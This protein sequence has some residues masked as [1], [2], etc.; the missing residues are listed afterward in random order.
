MSNLAAIYT[1]I[2][3][4]AEG[5][6]VGVANQEAA[7][8]ALAERHGL[9][10][11]E[12]YSDND[13]GASIHSRKPRI[14]FE[15]MMRDAKA[16]RFGTVIAYSMSRVSRRPAE[17]EVLIQMGAAGL[18][19]V[20]QVSP[21]YDLNTADG[22][23]TARTVSAWDAA[24]AERTSERRR[25]RNDGNTAKGRPA[26]RPRVFGYEVDG[27]TPR[28]DEAELLRAG[29]QHVLD[30]GTVRSLAARWNEEG[31]RS[32]RGN[33]W[34]TTVVRNTLLRER[35][36]GI[37]IARGERVEGSQIIPIVD[38]EV[39]QAVRAILTDAT[40]TTKG[41]PTGERW[42]S[43]AMQCQCG[44]PMLVGSSWSN[45][46][47]SP[48]YRCESISIAERSGVPRERGHSS[49][50]ASTV[51]EGVVRELIAT[52]VVEALTGADEALPEAADVV[53]LRARQSALEE[54]RR[55]AQDMYMLPGVDRAHLASRIARI[56]AEHDAVAADLDAAL[57]A[58]SSADVVKALRAAVRDILSDV[59]ADDEARGAAIREH[60]D[61]LSVEVRRDVVKAKLSITVAPGGSGAV[62]MKRVSIHPV[63][64][65]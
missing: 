3:R 48:A 52:L 40:R 54:E 13:R 1:R 30:G 55:V 29:Y 27:M 45:R 60:W 21:T 43:G 6:E 49:I 4:D 5:L 35:N 16:K 65:P 19:Y 10:V 63:E 18:R 36:A 24:E 15:R 42:L 26:G 56:G 57:T 31:L 64:R 53:R 17:W 12:V 47:Y 37:L 59:P 25:F 62:G 2:S 23:A 61:A 44:R 41:R 9:D 51:E 38:L 34:S 33:P 32:L 58:R 14:G 7:C 39:W 20:Y 8:R 50:V 11:V 22:R 28:E 46:V